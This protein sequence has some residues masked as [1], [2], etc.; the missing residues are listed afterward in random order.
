MYKVLI[1]RFD[2]RPT[3]RQPVSK[4]LWEF[5]KNEDGT[6][7]ET[8]NLQEAVDKYADSPCGR[9]HTTIVQDIKITST[10]TIKDT[11]GN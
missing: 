10:L 1:H 7:F 8:N 4:P 11:L 6:V 9:E 5:L 2:T 3:K